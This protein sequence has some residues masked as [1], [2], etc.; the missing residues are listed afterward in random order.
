MKEFFT[1]VKRELVRIRWPKRD[2][3]VKY[4]IATI[5]FIIFLMLVFSSIDLIVYFIRSIRG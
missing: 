4:S 1:G 3:M 5:T 2:E